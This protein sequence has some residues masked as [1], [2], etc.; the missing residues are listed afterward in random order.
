MAQLNGIVRDTLLDIATKETSIGENTMYNI[1]DLQSIALTNEQMT[2]ALLPS[3]CGLFKEDSVWL[4]VDN[5][6]GATYTQYH[7]YK[8]TVANKYSASASA[9]WTDLGGLGGGGGSLI[10]WRTW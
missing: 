9:S 6:T 8:F 4:C 3:Q 1:T 5:P 7:F 2:N 10:T